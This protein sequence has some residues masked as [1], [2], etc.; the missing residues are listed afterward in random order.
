M[1]NNYTIDVVRMLL[2]LG[3][4]QGFFLTIL[5]FT[6]YRSHPANRFLGFLVLAYSLFIVNTMLFGVEVLQRQYPHWLMILSGLPFLFGPLHMIYVGEL[7]ESHLKFT[8]MN[9]YHFLPFIIYKLY[10]IQ[11]FFLSD[12]E[13]FSVMVQ[14][15]QNDKPFHIIFS[16]LMISIVGVF[17][18]IMAL[19]VFKRYSQKIQNV[20][21]SLDKVNLYWLRFFTY[22]ALFV[23]SIVFILNLLSAYSIDTEPY[24]MVVPVL[25]SIFVYATGY[26]GIFK[27]DIFEQQG[28]RKN[29]SQAYEIEAMKYISRDEKRYEKSGLSGEKAAGSL[30]KLQQLMEQEKPYLNSNLTLNDLSSKLEISGHNLS[31]I[32]NTQLNQ[33]FFDFINQYRINEVK[34]YLEDGSKDHLTLLSIALDAGFNSKSGFNLVFKK[35]MNITPSEYRQ[36]VRT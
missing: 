24:Y 1:Q 14:I 26:I 34:K 18:I 31:E 36:K 28:V 12:E 25:T 8:R 23:W 4:V 11:V 33:N 16:S 30:K 15:N 2:I 32:L 29:L 27:T 13:L 6:K 10:Y 22:A 35:F 7:T 21:S 3:A 20:F 19:F 17:Y 5:L 9:W